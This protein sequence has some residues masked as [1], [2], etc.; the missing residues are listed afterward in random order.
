MMSDREPPEPL[1]GARPTA[2]L[3]PALVVG[4][5]CGAYVAARRTGNRAWQRN[6]RMITAFS[7]V[8]LVPRVL[9]Q[10]ASRRL[11]LPLMAAGALL[12]L[13]GR[14]EG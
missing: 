13:G 11:M 9:G 4:L 8:M 12:L 7:L 3:W 5:G 1:V 2:L 10:G 6:S 14:G